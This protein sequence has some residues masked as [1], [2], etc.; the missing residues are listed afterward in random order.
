M[1]F[2]DI[3]K[4]CTDYPALVIAVILGILLWSMVIVVALS[5]GRNTAE[6]RE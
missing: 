4:F 3:I 2:V 1:N 6:K 5:G